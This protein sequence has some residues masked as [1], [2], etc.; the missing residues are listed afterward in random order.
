MF[1]YLAA[2]LLALLLCGR[3]VAGDLP[4]ASITL[5]DEV[6]LQ[7]AWHDLHGR[8]VGVITNQTGVTSK[9]ISIV[10]AI[11]ANPHICIKAIYAPEHGLR[12]DHPAGSSVTSYADSQTGLPV[13]SLYGA[14]RHPSA[15]MLKGVDV[16]L[17]DIQDVGDRAYTF[18]STMAYAMQSAKAM[19]KPIW[20]LDRPNPI[21]GEIVEGPVLDPRFKSFIGLYPIAMRH[22]MTVGELAQMYNDAFGIHA[23]L[24]VIAMRGWRR[25]MLW[26][27]TGLQWV[28]SSPN[29]PTWQTTLVYP[30]TG[31]IDNAGIN[32]GTGFTKPFEYAGAAGL[33]GERLA[34]RLNARN[35][36]GVYFR[37]AHWSPIAGFW[38]EKE[39]SGVELVVYDPQ[40]FLAV[41]SGLEILCAVRAVDPRFI[42]IKNPKALDTDWG[43]DSLRLGLKSGLTPEQIEAQW[44]P[45]LNAFMKLRQRYLLY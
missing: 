39:L 28:Q 2:A 30:G 17:F 18:I 43:T 22:G 37:P 16:L 12:G 34:A 10:D 42:Q 29:I 44:Q 32:N 3:A 20:I 5:G 1:R 25:S 40:T 19:H 26:P 15:A 23:D 8:C 45:R 33:N 41:R 35:L 14:T 31:L 9:L 38:K 4:S 11:K 21:G 27:Q 7:A 36:P 6:F 13:Y 24:R